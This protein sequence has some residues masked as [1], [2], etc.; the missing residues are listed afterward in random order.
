MQVLEAEQ[1]PDDD[2]HGLPSSV[3]GPQD[4]SNDAAGAPAEGSSAQ[5]SS[6]V[7]DHAAGINPSRANETALK[8]DSNDSMKQVTY[9]VGGEAGPSVQ[10]APVQIS[11]DA[12]QPP[13]AEQ[14][15]R[16]PPR[17][18][19][20]HEPQEPSNAEP[21]PSVSSG[22]TFSAVL[23]L[24]SFTLGRAS[25]QPSPAVDLAAH[26]EDANADSVVEGTESDDVD[27]AY[28]KTR[29]SDKDGC[30]TEKDSL[31]SGSAAGAEEEE[32]EGSGTSVAKGITSHDAAKGDAEEA[33]SAGLDG[34]VTGL[35]G[36]FTRDDIGDASA[37]EP[38]ATDSSHNAASSSTTDSSPQR[39]TPAKGDNPPTPAGGAQ[40]LTPA[41]GLEKDPQGP[42]PPKAEDPL[43]PAGD[44]H[45]PISSE[46]LHLPRKG[47]TPPKARTPLPQPVAHR[48]P[49]FLR[50]ISRPPM[51]HILLKVA[52]SRRKP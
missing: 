10:P 20:H 14:T 33:D 11:G 6:G 50:M 26:L 46:S 24:L 43:Y 52:I 3:R 7:Q 40:G 45:S 15:P 31:A 9:D 49:P 4:G 35:D 13:R 42:T 12:N 18:V 32:I 19:H 29:G 34:D 23:F 22:T 27:A 51:V 36:D 30:L 48:A 5:S 28:A 38:A 17:T 44:A 25:M 1:A 8:N 41:E 39:P 2:A 21:G 37:A 47:P 16:L